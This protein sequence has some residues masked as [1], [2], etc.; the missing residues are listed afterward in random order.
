MSDEEKLLQAFGLRG[1][2]GEPREKAIESIL[3]TLNLRMGLKLPE[4][5]PEEKLD[6]YSALL[7]GEPEPQVVA[8]WLNSN[9][10]NYPELIEK[11]ARAMIAEKDAILAKVGDK[12]DQ[13]ATL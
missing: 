7:D 6:E 8:E 9:I 4:I 13:S 11:E 1:L 3:N 12:S 10:E 5:L 2:T